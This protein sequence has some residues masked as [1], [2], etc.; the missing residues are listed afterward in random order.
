MNR[1]ELIKKKA[2][3]A[4]L[5]PTRAVMWALEYIEELEAQK[6][7]SNW[8]SIDTAPKNGEAFLGYNPEYGWVGTVRFDDPEDPNPE[9]GNP[10]WEF[11]GATVGCTHWM[12]LPEPPEA[13]KKDE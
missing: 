8:K 5:Y 7:M 13:E 4:R 2:A 3:L 12:P 10:Q 9:I 11:I 1:E 6:K